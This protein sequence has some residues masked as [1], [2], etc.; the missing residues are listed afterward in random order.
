MNI[1]EYLC[2]E[3]R[4][5]TEASLKDIKDRS[6]WIETSAE[7]RR[8]F[9]DMLGLTYY[10]QSERKP[11]KPVVTG[12]LKRDGYR[13]E[14]LYFQSLPGLYVTGNLYIP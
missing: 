7:R 13:V 3:A 9:I 8:R 12:V 6:Y 11:V 1:F 4:K 5:I 14:K 2:R 10:M